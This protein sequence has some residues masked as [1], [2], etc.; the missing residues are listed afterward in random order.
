SCGHGD[1][2]TYR[3]DHEA[4]KAAQ[5][6]VATH[7]RGVVSMG[8]MARGRKR[9]NIEEDPLDKL[10]PT[11]VTAQPF[12]AGEIVARHAAFKAVEPGARGFFRQL[13]RI[14]RQL[15]GQFAGCTERSAEVPLPEAAR[16]RPRDLHLQLHEAILDLGLVAIPR[17]AMQIALG[18]AL[19]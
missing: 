9:L 5:H 6:A 19:G 14:A 17:E 11:Y 3:R 15:D 16:H 18:A 7:A 4:A 12:G 2:C 1:E 10:P 13:E 8:E